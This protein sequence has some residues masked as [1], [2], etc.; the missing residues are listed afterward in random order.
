MFNF[1]FMLNY[2][3]HLTERIY[4]SF[5]KK[6]FPSDGTSGL[7]QVFYLTSGLSQVAIS[8]NFTQQTYHTLHLNHFTK[9]FINT[10]ITLEF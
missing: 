6:S 4:L 8:Q 10:L 9:S 1:K 5:Q 3:G 2:V 7:T